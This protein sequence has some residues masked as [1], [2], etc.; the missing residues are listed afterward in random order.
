MANAPVSI[1]RRAGQVPPNFLDRW[2]IRWSPSQ[3][4]EVVGSHPE[5]SCVIGEGWLARDQ[6]AVVG[7]ESNGCEVVVVCGS[8]DLLANPYLAHELLLDFASQ[9]ADLVFARLDLSAGEL[10]H[11][12]Q[13]AVGSPLYA[14]HETVADDDSTDDLDCSLHRA[15]P[16]ASSALGWGGA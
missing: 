4:G 11:A 16:A 10:P 2:D 15:H 8:R 6:V 3:V 9:G 14:V 7:R 12:R 1:F 13:A 5:F